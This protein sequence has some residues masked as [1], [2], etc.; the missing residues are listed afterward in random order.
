ML[1]FEDKILNQN[2]GNGK[3]ATRLLKEFSNKADILNTSHKNLLTYLTRRLVLLLS[4]EILWQ[5]T[6]KR[7]VCVVLVLPGSVETQLGV[8]L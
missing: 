3:N 8:K 5:L 7:A 1:N 6:S 2:H 4:N